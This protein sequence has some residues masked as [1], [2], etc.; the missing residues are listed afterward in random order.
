MGL[1]QWKWW[2]FGDKFVNVFLFKVKRIEPNQIYCINRFIYYLVHNI[3][4]N[5]F[6][7]NISKMLNIERKLISLFEFPSKQMLQSMDKFTLQ[8]S[9]NSIYINFAN[10]ICSIF[11]IPDI[12]INSMKMEP[13]TEAFKSISDGE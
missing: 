12:E 1:I 2:W 4:L 6:E 9:P 13:K 3:Q 5:S 11:R 8:T 10:A 7:K